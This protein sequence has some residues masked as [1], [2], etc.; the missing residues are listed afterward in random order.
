MSVG[1]EAIGVTETARTPQRPKLALKF[2]KRDAWVGVYWNRSALFNFED[3]TS[4]VKIPAMLIDSDLTE[5]YICLLPFLPIKIS[6]IK[7]RKQSVVARP[8]T[9]NL[10]LNRHTEGSRQHE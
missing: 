8:A 10:G 6:W 3:K 5:I 4:D 2:E 1:S 9:P 7:R